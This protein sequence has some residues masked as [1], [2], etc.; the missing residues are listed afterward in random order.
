[1]PPDKPEKTAE[2]TGV[3]AVETPTAVASTMPEVASQGTGARIAAGTRIGER[4]VIGNYIASGG[5]GDVYE[6]VDAELRSKLAVK[7]IHSHLA[8][9][10]AAIERVRREVTLART[11]TDPHVCRIFDLAHAEVDGRSLTFITMELLEGESL[12]R[13]LRDR[14]PFPIAT[15]YVL[16]ADLCHGLEACHRAGVIHRD[17]KAENVLLVARRDREHAVLTDFGIARLH[18]EPGE[19]RS[20]VDDSITREGVMV[21]SPAFMASEQIDGGRVTP[22]TDV[23]ALG[24]LLWELAI[25]RWPLRGLDTTQIVR[26]FAQPLTITELPAGVDE[27]WRT[28]IERCLRYDPDERFGSALEVLAALSDETTQVPTRASTPRISTEPGRAEAPRA[29]GKPS[30][31]PRYDRRVIAGAAIAALGVAAGVVWWKSRGN[32]K[33]VAHARPAAVAGARTEATVDGVRAALARL[34]FTRALELAHGLGEG[35]PPA[36][37][38]YLIARAQAGL[39]DWKAAAA[40]VTAATSARDGLTRQMTLQ[41]EAIGDRASGDLVAGVPVLE[42][43]FKTSPDDPEPGFELVEE[44]IPLGRDADAIRTLDLVGKLK[45]DDVAAAR[46]ALDRAW[47][48][49]NTTGYD[50]SQLTALADA[51]IAAATPIDATVIRGRALLLRGASFLFRGQPD[52]AT[53]DVKQAAALLEA[54]HDRR[55]LAPATRMFAV[56]AS[57]TSSDS[58]AGLALAEKAIDA[59]ASVDDRVSLA[60]SYNIAAVEAMNLGQ[61]DEAVKA[62]GKSVAASVAA[63]REDIADTRTRPNWAA[64][65]DDLGHVD[66]GIKMLEE[67]QARRGP[68]REG[69]EEQ[70]LAT[71]Y[72]YR[73]ELDK[74]RRHAAL[75]L[76]AIEKTKDETFHA[77]QYVADAAIEYEADNAKAYSA[78]IAH[79]E[80][81]L[82]AAGSNVEAPEL[83]AIKGVDLL[84]RDPGSALKLFTAPREP[85]NKWGEGMV[86]V[87][88][89][90]A[91]ARLGKRTEAAAEL[92]KYRA[93]A[94]FVQFDE[95][96]LHAALLAAELADTAE[97]RDAAAREL[98]AARDA[99][100]RD[101]FRL[102][103][104][105][106]ELGMAA[107]ASQR[108]DHATASKLA[109]EVERKATAAGSLR[110]AREARSSAIKR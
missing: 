68:D 90:R 98:G 73:G 53:A 15:A 95:V 79:A 20:A 34:E 110:V 48:M 58:L 108:G 85:L 16:A 24:A 8:A 22:R 94:T 5:M 31:P 36:V 28:T 1:M 7:V 42:A 72:R 27:R 33:V 97:T 93:E 86:I 17:L 2:Q 66:E 82:K 105:R 104:W 6:A 96:R 56:I 100:L 32:A 99:A 49:Y 52:K 55:G 10:P 88:A 40:A 67:L 39:G 107:L 61:V 87:L 47:R 29:I 77:A 12:R 81:M 46:L 3:T 45:L 60:L 14:G 9:D 101:G 51:A 71:L 35:T 84:E 25:G 59:A 37:T 57:N 65:D 75:A 62:Y 76:A 43:L 102:A 103:Q 30:S 54:A 41:L 50:E 83:I 38:Q 44:L 69:R 64:L 63:Q 92:A 19:P 11:V 18:T 106:A 4:Y 70:N 78:A 80:A 26:R 91:Y 23:Y 74:A 109:R 89:G 21:G 13:R